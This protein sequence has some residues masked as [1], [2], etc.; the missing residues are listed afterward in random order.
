MNILYNTGIYLLN[1][2]AHILALFNS[3]ARL[4]IDGTREWENKITKKITSDDKCIWVHA[5]SLGEFEQGRPVI[6]A[7]KNERSD[8]KIVLTFTWLTVR[9]F[10]PCLDGIESE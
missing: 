4:W 10:N 1:A 5:A 2:L 8:L 3:K 9:P 6:E 7:L